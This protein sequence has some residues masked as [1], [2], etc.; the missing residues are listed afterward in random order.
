MAA[1]FADENFPQQVVEALRARGHD[2]LTADDAGLANRAVSDEDI[3]NE[4][5][6]LRRALL[7]LNRWEFIGRHITNPD[8]AGLVV[9][10]EDPDTEGQAARIEAALRGSEPL[11]G[12]LIRVNRPAR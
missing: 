4:A 1:L 7:T 11:A 6:R 3:L 8:H 12:Q 9:C 10:T 2:A 5:T